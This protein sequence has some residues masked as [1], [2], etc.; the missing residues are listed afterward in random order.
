M[1]LQFVTDQLKDQAVTAAKVAN[2]TIT[3]TQMAMDGTFAFSGTVSSSQAPTSDSHVANKAYVD[4]IAAGLH[5]K[6][7]VRAA[8]TANITLS[9]T[10]TIDGIALQ[11][12]D[13]VLVKN[14]SDAE[15]NGIYV[16]AAG[17]WS[18]SADMNAGDEFPGAA[19]FVREGTVYGD[20][21]WVCTNDA[22]PT[23]GTT[24]IAF[25]Q[26]SGS[27]T[28][29]GG[30]GVSISGN[31]IAVDLVDS[32]S[33][34]DFASGEL[35]IAAGGVTNAM[36]A[37][38]IADSKLSTIATANKVSGTAVQLAAANATIEN[39][40]G[41]QV[42]IASNSGL[43]AANAG[44]ALDLDGSTLSMGA[45]GVKVADGGIANAQIAGN[46]AIADSKLATIS[47]ANKVSGSAVQLQSNKGLADD[48]GLGLVLD[49]ATLSVGASGLKVGDGALANAQIAGNAAIAYSKLALTGAILNADLAGSIAD[50]KLSTIST[51]DKVSGSA[52]QLATDPGIENSTGLRVK[53]AANGGLERIGDGVGIKPAGVDYGMLGFSPRKDAFTGNGNATAF[54]LGNRISSPDWR[55]GVVVSRNGQ[56]LTQLSSGADS[57]D[58]YTVTDNGSATTVT[59]GAA[60]LSGDVINVQ[61]F[62]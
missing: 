18:R 17:A 27:G 40:S 57:V 9:G 2:G 25:A 11:A 49:G 4:N 10:Q 15:D 38:S 33:G 12:A 16:V 14:Q 3:Q 30:D 13:R 54:Q 53:I 31:T 19:M 7:S 46:A 21:G 51:A 39:Q 43:E 41:L 6:D 8:T 58:E 20:T 28:F 22:E 36:L 60:P 24:A 23:V 26:F 1:P 34:L 45:S 52:V 56:V 29:V 50:S 37:G 44:L 61:Y 47:T 5:W 32:G 62:G 48:S 55:D 59:F 35:Q 42:K